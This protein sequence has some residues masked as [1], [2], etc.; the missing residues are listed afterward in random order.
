MQ[1]RRRSRLLL[2]ICNGAN[3]GGRRPRPHPVGERRLACPNP[4]GSKMEIGEEESLRPFAVVPFYR[5][6]ISK[7]HK[8]A[9]R[10]LCGMVRFKWQLRAHVGRCNVGC[11]LSFLSC[12]SR[13]V[14]PLSA[15]CTSASI[16]YQFCGKASLRIAASVYRSDRMMNG[17]FPEKLFRYRGTTSKHFDEELEQLR[18]NRVW[19]NFLD[20]QNDPFEGC[21]SHRVGTY[22]EFTSRHRE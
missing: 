5:T 4:A 15:L 3:A 10:C 14:T 18:D 22:D 11:L 6:A 2:G 13:F 17:W 19:L 21:V 16:F 9:V 7:G 20:T 8:A 1:T 12:F